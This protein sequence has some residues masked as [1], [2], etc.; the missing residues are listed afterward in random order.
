MSTF[1]VGYTLGVFCVGVAF[2]SLV[3]LVVLL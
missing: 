3:T 1:G 2:G